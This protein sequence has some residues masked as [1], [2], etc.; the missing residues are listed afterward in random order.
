MDE[1]MCLARGH[2]KFNTSVP[3]G[4]K[5]LQPLLVLVLLYTQWDHN[6]NHHPNHQKYKKED[7]SA[8]SLSHC[9]ASQ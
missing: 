8:L 2:A 4:F 6:E 9:L 1:N 7:D 3:L 5:S